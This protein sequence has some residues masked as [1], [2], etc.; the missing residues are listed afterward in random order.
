[1]QRLSNFPSIH[2]LL[3]LLLFL[4]A[5]SYP[6]FSEV[7]VEAEIHKGQNSGQPF[8]DGTIVVK[9]PSKSQINLSSFQMNGKPLTVD[10]IKSIYATSSDGKEKSAISTFHFKIP[11]QSEGLH[12]L[13]AIGVTID[14]HVYNS[15][16]VSYEVNAEEMQG[17]LI[18][19][20]EIVGIVPLYPGQRAKMI[21]QIYFKGTINLT[22]E[23]L[24]LL[25]AKGLR[26]VGGIDI[27]ENKSGDYDVQI[28]S[29]EIE[30]ISPGTLV[31]GPSIIEGN[32][33]QYVSGQ[34]EPS[35]TLIRSDLPS[36]S[37]EILPFPEQGKPPSFN[38]TIGLF[39]YEFI[40]LSSPRMNLGDR[41]S[42]CKSFPLAGV[43]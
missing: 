27:Q 23:V 37:L 17:P 41:S 2:M 24:P 10:F 36:M 4:M 9:H 12:L 40:L 5:F 22:K 38:G 18:L 30:A 39:S 15:T 29:Q 31:F 3:I 19:K 14:G 35:Q 28:I 16:P 21:Y 1:M 42:N 20:A 7:N 32:L 33:Y 25:D 13:P 43:N 6:L 34:I 8:L 26:K 11:K